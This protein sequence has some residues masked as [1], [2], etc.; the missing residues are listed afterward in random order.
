MTC[1][2]ISDSEVVWS[3]RNRELTASDIEF[4]R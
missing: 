1:G 2:D 4:L 3:Y